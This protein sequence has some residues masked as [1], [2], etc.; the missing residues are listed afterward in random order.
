[1]KKTAAFSLVLLFVFSLSCSKLVIKETATITVEWPQLGRTPQRINFI[2]ERL[3]LP[4][5]QKWRHRASSAVGPSLVAT[6]GVVLYGTL[7]GR[8]E[9]VQ[10]SSGKKVGRIKIRGNFT[11][12]CALYDASLIMVRRITQ[13]TLAR[14]DLKTGKTLWKVNNAAVFSEPLV[15]GDKVYLSDLS[16]KLSCYNLT[17]GAKN[18]SVKLK[19]QSHAAPAL[20]D[21]LILV[22]DDRGLLHAYNFSGS[23]QW[24]FKTNAPIYASPTCSAGTIYFGS[25]DKNFYAIKTSD[26]KELWH[27]QTQG[28]I[29]NSAAVS[30]DYVVF[31]STDHYVYCLDKTSGKLIWRFQAQSVISTAPVIAGEVVFIGSLDKHLYALDLKNGDKL[32]SFEAK[33]RIRTNPIIVNKKL[34]FASENDKLYCF[35]EK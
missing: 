24:S 14:Y 10:I 15:V 13:P 7:D 27:Y 25:T 31:G 9:G 3:T 20:A 33:G 32:W 30:G 18:W 22:G 35:G 12:T 11:A 26:G 34:L 19:G 21:S 17:D 5:E 4:L 2:P 8:I 1:M 23:E 28:K 6:N 16:G 29:Y